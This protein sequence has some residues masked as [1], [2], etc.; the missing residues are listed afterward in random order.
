PPLYTLSLHD[1]LP[2][3]CRVRSLGR[4]P[5]AIS[6]CGFGRVCWTVSNLSQK[7]SISLAAR[8][9]P[10]DLSASLLH[11]E[12]LSTL[13]APDRDKSGGRSEEHTSELQSRENL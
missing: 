11:C 5:R 12:S 3:C 1:A 10:P 7:K 6:S 4:A 2:I 8:S 13:Q 9:V